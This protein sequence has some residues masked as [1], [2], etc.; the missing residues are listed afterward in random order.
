ML[1]SSRL[2]M[3][4]AH[5]AIEEGELHVWAIPEDAARAA[6]SSLNQDGQTG[7]KTVIISLADQQL[8]GVPNPV[9]C[10]PFYVLA[11]LTPAELAKLTEAIKTD[12]NIKQE[13]IAVI[14]GA[15]ESGDQVV[16]GAD[17]ESAPT[18]TPI[19][20]FQTEQF[21]REL[22]EHVKD[23]DWHEENK[24]RYQ[25]VLRDPSQF[26][27]DQL[28]AR[29]IQRLN[30][31]V[32][33]G[34]NHLSRLKKN[35]FGQGGYHDHYWFA[36]YDPAAGSK[37]KSAQLFVRFLGSEAT[38]YYGFSMGNQCDAYMGR[39][40]NAIAANR[41]AVANYVRTAPAGTSVWLSVGTSEHR[42]SPTEF[43]D[44]IN[45]D[46]NGIFGWDESP[47][48]ISIV[49]EYPLDDLS[50]HAES[51]VQETGEYFTWA[52]PFF[53]AAVS[54]TWQSAKT[55]PLVGA[56]SGWR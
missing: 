5:W 44:R 35:D 10:E 21:L 53:D 49:R 30:P 26:I 28:A 37:I 11:E 12:D 4:S 40:L 54:G 23:S 19:Y 56:D 50:D 31:A 47:T 2:P 9:N 6:F 3:S 20:T 15:Q 51:F 39:L 25:R 55:P 36:F 24:G 8:K 38:W 14:E 43:A 7:R 48:S 27:V 1:S 32:A 18:E 17:G 42:I 46:S 41:G 45:N 29:Y 33:G 34:K 52:W 22:P 13:R 16:E